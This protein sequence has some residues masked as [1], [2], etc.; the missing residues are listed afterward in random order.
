MSRPPDSK[1]GPLDE[2]ACRFAGGVAHDFSNFLAV[3]SGFAQLLRKQ[4]KDDVELV[5]S[6]EEILQAS[7]RAARMVD[8][9]GLLAGQRALDPRPVDLNALI[10]QAKE[11]LQQLVGDAIRLDVRVA[12]NP[13]VAQADPAR[14]RD[15]LSALCEHVKADLAGA[16]RITITT[17]ADPANGHV[18]VSVQ[19]SGKG[20]EPDLVTRAFE[21][22]FLKSRLKRGTGLGLPFAHAV[23]KQHG[24]SVEIDSAPGQGTTFHLSFPSG[25]MGP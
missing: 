3:I 9:L 1:P 4:H 8:H 23:V 15:A 21:P 13:L 14:V 6:L 20:L 11:G 19:D 18:R 16:G 24:G 17:A 2:A 10:L 5:E 22:F 12:P 25:K 7:E